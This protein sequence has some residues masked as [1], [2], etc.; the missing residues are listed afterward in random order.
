MSAT[1]ILGI[2][3]ACGTTVSFLPQAI[4]TIYTKN[5]SGI[6]LE[7]YAIVVTGTVLWLIY[8][9]MIGSWPVIMAN[10][11]TLVVASVI[12]VYKIIYK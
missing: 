12:L 7:M 6:S 5:T 3:A 11:T 4:K 1:T 8:G 2:L 9:L 10:A